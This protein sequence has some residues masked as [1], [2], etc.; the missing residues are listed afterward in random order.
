MEGWRCAQR[1]AERLL[2]V[3]FVATVAHLPQPVAAARF[4]PRLEQHAVALLLVGQLD[5]EGGGHGQ[6][7]AVVLETLI[8]LQ[9]EQ[10]VEALPHL[11]G[12]RMASSG[13]HTAQGAWAG[14]GEL[15]S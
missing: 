10:R 13:A 4:G 11:L 8:R 6:R 15:C 12:G 2:V 1:V 7:L 14:R 3:L 9:L 5:R